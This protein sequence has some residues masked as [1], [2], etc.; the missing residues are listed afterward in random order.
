MAKTNMAE[1]MKARRL[2]RRLQLIELLGGKCTDCDTTENLEFNHI[3]RD[4]KLFELSGKSLDTKWEVILEEANK[5]ELVCKE[6]HLERTR[7]QYESGQIKIWNDK[8]HLPYIHGTM[9]CYQEQGCRCDFCKNAKRV[10]R[11]GNS[12]YSEVI[13]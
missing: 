1:Y 5:C 3:D 9:R 13:K 2:K 8:K 12:K 10:Y 4:S 11:S 6:H 7:E